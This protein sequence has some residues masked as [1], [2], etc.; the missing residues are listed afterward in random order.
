RR[1]AGQ[2]ARGGPAAGMRWPLRGRGEPTRPAAERR[3]PEPALAPAAE[4]EPAAAKSSAPAA[5]D[6]KEDT[7]L[8]T[9]HFAELAAALQRPP[10]PEAK[11]APMRATAPGGAA[12]DTN[13]PGMAHR[14]PGGGRRPA[15][16]P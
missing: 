10:G 2:R 9:D 7:A 16:P 1:A 6:T 8:P 13:L 15:P 3:A 11:P 5:E 14:P 4:P 12:A